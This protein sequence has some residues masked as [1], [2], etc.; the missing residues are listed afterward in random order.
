MTVIPKEKKE[1]AADVGTCIYFLYLNK[2]IVY[3]G[4]SGCLVAR[5]SCHH[6]HR[7]FDS[8]SF[9]EA[10]SHELNDLEALSIAHHKPVGN[11]T[12]PINNHY[13]SHSRVANQVK[14]AVM[15]NIKELSESFFIGIA[16]NKSKIK[17]IDN[18]LCHQLIDHINNFKYN[19]EG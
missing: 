17:Y 4:Q 1:I 14:D 2:E 9:V 19:N 12:L 15:D 8:F 13:I 3:I 11:K 10:K 7:D 5:L 16:P 6:G 18:N